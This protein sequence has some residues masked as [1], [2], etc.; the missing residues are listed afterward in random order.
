LIV[1]DDILFLKNTVLNLNALTNNLPDYFDVISLD[2]GDGL[3]VS[4]YLK[5]V[6]I[7]DTKRAYK[8]ENGRMR[9]TGSY[10]INKKTCSKL[11]KLN[12]KRKFSLEIDMQLWLYGKL[13]LLNVFWAEPIIFTQGSQNNT[14]TS[15]IQENNQQTITDTPH[16]NDDKHDGENSVNKDCEYSVFESTFD[17]M[18]INIKRLNK[19]CIDLCPH[20]YQYSKELIKKLNFSVLLFQNETD[21]YYV[22]DEKLKYPIKYCYDVQNIDKSFYRRIDATIKDCLFDGDVDVIIANNF[23]LVEYLLFESV[24]INPKIIFLFNEKD[25]ID[26]ISNNIKK[27]K[28]RY[29]YKLIDKKHMLF[30]KQ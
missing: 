7:D 4:N 24:I 3:T 27:L 13:K 30:F 25:S 29:S 5:D 26:E 19:R 23:E 8:I 28:Y 12:K 15:Q 18:D 20:H 6:K 1:E 17:N 10:I 21:G 11:L 16:T 14:Y 22:S 2:N 9:F